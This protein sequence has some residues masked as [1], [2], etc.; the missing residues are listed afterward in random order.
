[1]EEKMKKVIQKLKTQFGSTL[2]R[3]DGLTPENLSILLYE[4]SKQINEAFA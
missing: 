4:M 2:D 1:M 3:S